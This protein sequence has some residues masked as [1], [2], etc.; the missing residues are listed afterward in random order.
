MKLTKGDKILIAVLIIF[1]LFF[2]Y[3]MSTVDKGIEGKYVSVQINGKEINKIPFSDKI[4]GEKLEV[5]TE[6]GRNV[7]EFGD[8]EVKIIEASCLDKLCIKQGT[9]TKVG[10]LI[11]CLPNRLV[12]EIKHDNSNSQIDNVIF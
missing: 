3:Y 8:N 2:A 7:L 4:I 1:S 6:F 12:I 9:I 11:V 10:E 5:E